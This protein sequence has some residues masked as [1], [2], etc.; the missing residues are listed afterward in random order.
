MTPFRSASDASKP[1]NLPFPDPGSHRWDTTHKDLRLLGWYVCRFSVCCAVWWRCS[2]QTNRPVDKN[3]IC[4]KLVAMG[5]LVMYH[6]I[7]ER[8]PFERIPYL[9]FF[10][11]QEPVQHGPTRTTALSQ[12]G[13]SPESFVSPFSLRVWGKVC[14]ATVIFPSKFCAPVLGGKAWSC[15]HDLKARH[16]SPVSKFRESIG[17]NWCRNHGDQIGWRWLELSTASSQ[18]SHLVSSCWLSSLQSFLTNP[19]RWHF[20][21]LYFWCVLV[22]ACRPENTVPEPSPVYPE[23]GL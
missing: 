17:N 3:G 12:T 23:Q 22:L 9:W 5:C 6:P 8:I 15:E 2:S 16:R 10:F 19:F 21:I 4:L 13:S 14:A 20:W 18:S 7:S 11:M 1:V